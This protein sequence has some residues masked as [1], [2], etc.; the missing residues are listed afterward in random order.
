MFFESSLAAIT[1]LVVVCW[2][3]DSLNSFSCKPSGAF[4]LRPIYVCYPFTQGRI[5]HTSLK[6]DNVRIQITLFVYLCVWS[7]RSAYYGIV[8]YIILHMYSGLGLCLYLYAYN[9]EII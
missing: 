5:M 2:D 6:I 3:E 8:P 1:A 7:Y 9:A 4:S